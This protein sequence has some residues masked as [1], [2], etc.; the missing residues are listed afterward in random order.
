[1]HVDLA[2]QPKLRAVLFDYGHT[3]VDWHLPEAPLREAYG[4]IRDRLANEARIELPEADDLVELVAHR[5][6]RAVDESY[7][8]DRLRELDIL[9]LF[10]EALG[11]LGF[12]P[13]SETIRWVAEKE[14]RATSADLVTPPE[15]IATLQ[16]L[17]DAGLKLGIVS[18]AHLLPDMMRWNWDQ[19]GFG[20]LI[21]ESIISCEIG[22]RKP[23]PQIFL[24]LLDRMGVSADE[25]VF[26]GDRALD[27]IEGAHGVGMRAI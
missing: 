3:L 20:H 5:V 15:T 19:L 27:D 23:H 8:N 9:A 10:E 11:S 17:H 7:Q 18:N 16:R 4:E 1:M 24:T 25:A 26:V 6:S 13:T 22:I 14:H 21:D 12:V 2:S